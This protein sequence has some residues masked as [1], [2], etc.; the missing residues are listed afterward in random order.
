MFLF[1]ESY[2]TCLFI[3]S[4]D[5]YICVC[6]IYTRQKRTVHLVYLE[7]YF[8]PISVA[9]I[10]V[11]LPAQ[12]FLLARELPIERA[13]PAALCESSTRGL[14]DNGACSGCLPFAMQP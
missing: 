9:G 10:T 4:K 7:V 8:L 2:E 12:Q 3:L 1:V 13:A 11:N 14:P 6:I 5:L